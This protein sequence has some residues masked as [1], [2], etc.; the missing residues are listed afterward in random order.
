[1]PQPS[2]LTTCEHA[3]RI[4]DA[5]SVARPGIEHEGRNRGLGCA[6]RHV[7]HRLR[8]VIDR[9]WPEP[10]YEGE[11]FHWIPVLQNS[12][13]KSATYLDRDM[14]AP[15][16]RLGSGPSVRADMGANRPVLQSVM[17]IKGSAAAFCRQSRVGGH[18]AHHSGI[19]RGVFGERS[20]HAV[21]TP[22]VHAN[23]SF[24]ATS[25]RRTSEPT[26]H[27]AGQDRFRARRQRLPARAAPVRLES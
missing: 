18:F 10:R 22:P 23:T 9:P 4:E 14:G 13:Q 1:V 19:L 11:T 3:H 17:K 21:P 20:L 26:P 15:P 25:E 12:R 27:D 6:A 2:A 8:R 5:S 24:I 7:G 16:A